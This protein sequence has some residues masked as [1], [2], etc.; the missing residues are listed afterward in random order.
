MALMAI[1]GRTLRCTAPAESAV[2]VIAAVFRE[3][4]FRLVSHHGEYPV[5]LR[6]GSEIAGI[7]GLGSEL[8]LPLMAIPGVR[9]RAFPSE[10]QIH[11]RAASDTECTLRVESRT[12][13][14]SSAFTQKRFTALLGS[15]IEQLRST[16]ALI[17]LGPLTDSATEPRTR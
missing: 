17:E 2:D 9:K 13:S 11:V 12:S 4:D 15:A 7:L 1:P 5:K 10:V 16:G 8:L 14:S 3:A 6:F